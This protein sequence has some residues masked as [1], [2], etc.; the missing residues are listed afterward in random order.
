MSITLL[1]SN[2][3]QSLNE[4]AQEHLLNVVKKLRQPMSLRH[5]VRLKSQNRES[6]CQ[7][8]HLQFTSPAAYHMIFSQ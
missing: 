7:E 8:T 2:I 5:Y 4:F 3:T 1:Q 6:T